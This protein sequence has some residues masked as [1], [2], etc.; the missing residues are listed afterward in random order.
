ME[1]ETAKY[2]VDVRDA[3]A[4]LS[5]FVANRSRDDYLQDQLLR[6][7]VQWQ[8]AVIGEAISQLAK[9]DHDTAERITD[10]RQIIS[11]RNILIHGYGEVN[12]EAVWLRIEQHLP[13]LISDVNQLLNEV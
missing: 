6:S 12:D 2:L 5:R 3:A 11:F 8:F 9:I 1:R 10:Y 4:A 7:G 13:I